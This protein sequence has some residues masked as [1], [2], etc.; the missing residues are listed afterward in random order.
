MKKKYVGVSYE[1]NDGAWRVER[2]DDGNTFHVIDHLENEPLLTLTLS[3]LSELSEFFSDILVD[4][5]AKE[6]IQISSPGNSFVS[7]VTQPVIDMR[8]HPDPDGLLS[9]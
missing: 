7:T 9:L 5:G 3:Q 1:S 2:E 8:F 6:K 4:I